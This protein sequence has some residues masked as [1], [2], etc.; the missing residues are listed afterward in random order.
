MALTT[1]LGITQAPSNTSEVPNQYS[2]EYLLKVKYILFSNLS[3]SLQVCLIIYI[4]KTV[5]NV[6]FKYFHSYSIVTTVN[7]LETIRSTSV[8]F[9][10]SVVVK[11]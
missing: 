4:Y 9:P 6:H 7:R 8:P 3:H 11:I 2:S 1:Q 10:D 5:P